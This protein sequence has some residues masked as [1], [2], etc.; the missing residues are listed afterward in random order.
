MSGLWHGANWTF[1]IWG[2]VFGAVYLLEKGAGALPGGKWT[3][4]PGSPGHVLLAGK[5]FLIVTLA[6]VFFRSAGLPQAL[7]MFRLLV[8][9]AGE[10]ALAIAPAT[11]T[12][13]GLF[14]ASDLIL[15]DKRFDTWL[16]KRA[17][18]LRWGIYAIL[19]FAIIAFAG[20]E[21]FP[22]IYFQF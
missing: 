11:W 4:R 19:I 15:F 6:W 13:L 2:G 17:L 7:D 20:V 3:P 22:F 16:D 8:R 14:L 21:N 1:L 5:T 12:F 18:P 10:T 9:P